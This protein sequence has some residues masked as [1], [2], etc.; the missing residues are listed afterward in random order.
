MTVPGGLRSCTHTTFS[1]YVFSNLTLVPPN[2][3][4]SRSDVMFVTF[5]LIG[6]YSFCI[7]PLLAVFIGRPKY[8]HFKTTIT[9]VHH[10]DVSKEHV[11]SACA[12]LIQKQSTS[13]LKNRSA[14][15]KSSNKGTWRNANT[16]SKI[17]SGSVPRSARHLSTSSKF[18]AD[19]TWVKSNS[20][21]KAGSQTH[22]STQVL[23]L[24]SVERRTPGSHHYQ[25]TCEKQ[26]SLIAKLKELLKSSNQK[27][28]AIAIVVQYLLDKKEEVDKQLKELSQELLTLHHELETRSST[29]AQLE[30]DGEELKKVYEEVIQKLSEEHQ[31]ELKGLEKKLEQLVHAEKEHLEENF[32]K[33]VENLREQLQKEVETLT[34]KNEAHKLELVATHA[35]N[36]ESL[37]RDNQQSLAELTRLHELKQKALEESFKE[38]QLLF[39]EQIAKLNEENDCLKEDI[40]IQEIAKAQMQKDQKIDPLILYLEQELESLKAVLEIKNEKIHDQEKKLMQM[41]KQMEKHIALDEKLKIVLQENEDLKVR[42][43]KHIAVS[44]QL[45]TEQVVLQESLQKESKVNKRLSMKNEELLWK[46]QNGDVLDPKNLS[47]SSSFSFQSSSNST[48]SFSGPAPSPR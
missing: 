26:I 28:E 14:S 20:S 38:R 34:S 27:F 47:T 22:P 46:L 8:Q 7:V 11:L 13:V 19:R 43:D 4:G 29:C 9:S 40:K 21:Q 35:K 23:D 42:M 30:K 10:K 33:D 37:E 16:P 31:N 5:L 6:S 45:S 32:K 36:L 2:T 39:E 41:E 25:V 44:R 12:N 3:S 15:V 24:H 18:K 48:S 17:L 1:P